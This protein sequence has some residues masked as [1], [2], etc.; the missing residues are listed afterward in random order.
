[1]SEP[2]WLIKAREYIGTTEIVG[3]KHNPKVVELWAKAKVP[4]KVNDD[5]TPWCA[6]FVSA[7][8]EETGYVSAQTGWA[9]AYL[10]WGQPIKDPVKGAVVVF[11]RGKGFGHVGFVV[12]KDKNGNLMVLGGNQGNAVNIKPFA[13]S[14][15]LGYRW[16][17]DKIVPTEPLP[18]ITSSG[19][20]SSSE[21]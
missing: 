20:L 21:A 2:S 4:E 6:A 5:E 16:P 9:R 3:K 1:M 17:R 14:R 19:R 10:E 7:V 18:I 8:L 12:G 13:V 11:S 15:V